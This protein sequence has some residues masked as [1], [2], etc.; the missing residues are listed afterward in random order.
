LDATKKLAKEFLR[1]K[2]VSPNDIASVL[3]LP[4]FQVGLADTAGLWDSSDTAGLWDSSRW[5]AVKE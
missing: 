2:N 4:A 5:C 3:E 1:L